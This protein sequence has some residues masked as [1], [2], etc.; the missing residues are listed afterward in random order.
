MKMLTIFL[1][2]FAIKTEQ[3]TYVSAPWSVKF[4]INNAG[5]D[6]DGTMDLA[7]SEIKFDP[8]RLDQSYMRVTL[9]PSSIR[10][11]IAI[12][13]KHL[14]RSDYFDVTLYPEIQI[15]SVRFKKTAKHAY[16]G[17]FKITVKSTTQIVSI[18]F[19]VKKVDDVL[20]YEADFTINRLDFKIGEESLT[21]SN[22]VHILVKGTSS[23][24][25]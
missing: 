23:L 8:R 14:Q 6:V 13:D 12:R 18:P 4:T 16:V 19:T 5:F 2:L 25:P 22:E 11:G 17:E 10:T 1:L 7:H 24:Y 20:H 15:Q 3:L 21:L 9:D